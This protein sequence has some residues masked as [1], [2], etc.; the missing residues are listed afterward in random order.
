MKKFYLIILLVVAGQTL[1]NPN[2]LPNNN[3]LFQTIKDNPSSYQAT[4]DLLCPSVKKMAKSLYTYANWGL[5]YNTAIVHVRK[6]FYKIVPEGTAGRDLALLE[7]ENE[8]EYILISHKQ[9]V[10]LDEVI[11]TTTQSCYSTFSNQT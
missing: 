9:R 3:L 10:G 4:L 2:N 1:A 11:H 7:L 6:K 8:V 5:T